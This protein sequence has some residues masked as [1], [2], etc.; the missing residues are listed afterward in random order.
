MTANVRPAEGQ[1]VSEL[2]T[3]MTRRLMRAT[4]LG[5]ILYWSLIALHLLPAKAMFDEYHLPTVRAW[6]W[7]FLPLD[8]LASFIGLAALRRAPKRPQSADALAAISLVLTSVAGGMALAYWA[9]RGQ[10]A[11]AWWLPNAFLLLFPLPALRRWS[12]S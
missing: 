12:R 11:L 2:L 10:F 7:S 9:I 1:R 8:L 6:N 4:D 3:P 5:F